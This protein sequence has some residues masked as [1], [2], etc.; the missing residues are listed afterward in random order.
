MLHRTL[1]AASLCSLLA[2]EVPAAT[3][4]AANAPTAT[5]SA[6]APAAQPPVTVVIAY[7][8]EKKTW[9][10]E[11]VKTWLA[12]MPTTKSGRPIKVDARAM[13][14]GDAA[15]S[16]LDG[17]LKAH[18]FSPASSAYV[19]LLNQQW[20]SQPGHTKPLVPAGDA[21]VLSPIVI[22]MW[23]PMAEALGWPKKQLGWS[24][25]LKVNADKRGWG[26]YGHP[27]WGSFKLGHTHP[28]FSNS[29]L[30]A[31]VAIA[32]A[33]AKKSR[34]LT[35]ADVD[36]KN[37]AKLLG[38]VEDTIV[39]YGKSTGFF[40]D[41]MVE[42]G[43]SYLSAAVLY[44]NLVVEAANKGKSALPLVAIYPVEGTFWSDHPYAV[45][46]ADW[47]GVDERD[48]AEQL[49]VFL[50]AKPAQTR[51]LALGFRPADPAIAIGAPVDAA[52]GV[53]P[54]QP[55]T[56]LDVPDGPVL[57]KL[58]EL[59]AKNKKP[60]HVVLVFD[61]SGSM[62]GAALNEA[63]AGARGFLD[64]LHD[65]DEVSLIFFDD[66]VMPPLGPFKLKDGKLQL[67]RAI[68]GVIAGGGTALYDAT[69]EA[70]TSCSDSAKKEHDRIQAVVVMT[71]G[72][73]SGHSMT[74]DTL[75]QKLTSTD[76]ESSVHVFTIA[77]G[78][79]AQEPVLKDIAAAGGGAEAK[80][81]VDDIVGVF[82]DM[83]SFF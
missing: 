53:D 12:G 78:E 3:P 58:L 72:A 5:P 43:P 74:L 34:G 1:I 60:T 20:L 16:I 38:D 27:E 59:W 45:L 19:A 57:Q 36:S 82:R 75:K 52:H 83:A 17:T 42:R 62:A 40:A 64:V 56:L 55:Q 54:K 11:Q 8:S 80:G 13:G 31:I 49:L 22:A 25:L 2:C 6:P 9:L 79:Q 39:H 32:Y 73:D 14:S 77:F 61:K 44:E 4:P 63:K 15:A 37:V 69:L 28:Q 67:Q 10:D 23:Q 48:A 33:G 29:G 65:N 26:A 76:G 81:K 47:V 68:D 35:A 41:K 51:A 46:D 7:G 66:K 30:Q 71:D 18:V 21:L 50:K 70:F 24:D